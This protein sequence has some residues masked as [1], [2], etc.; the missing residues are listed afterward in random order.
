MSRPIKLMRSLQM[1]E[2]ARHLVDREDHGKLD[3]PLGAL[4]V[5]EPRQFDAQ[6]L[7]IQEQ[8]RGLRLILRGG[9]NLPVDRQMREKRLDLRGAKFRRMPLVVE[10]NEAFN[11][12]DI[13]LLRA[14]A[15]VLAADGVVN[16][17][18]QSRFGLGFV[19]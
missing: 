14:N 6:D 18:E 11:P 19:S 10:E 9:G 1:V 8:Q 15:V 12:V 4:D 2:N 13:G 7:P 16:A 5:V 17:V 3:W